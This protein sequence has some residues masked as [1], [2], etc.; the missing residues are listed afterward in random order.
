MIIDF[1]THAP[2]KGDFKVFLQDMDANK[3]DLSVLCPL[4]TTVTEISESNDYIYELTKQHPDRC[5]GFASVMPREPDAAK[6]LEHYIKDYGFK[7][8]KLHPPIQNFSPI[9][10]LIG[11]VIEKCIELDIP[12]L[13]HTGPIYSQNSIT[14]FGSPFLLDEL[15]IRYPKA[16]IV[17]AHVDPLAGDPAIVYK[18][19]NMFC[20]ITLRVAYL[21]QVIPNIGSFLL[22]QLRGDDNRILFGTDANP[23]RSWRF[24]YNLDAVYNMD[25]PEES[26]Q[27][28]LY[29]N[30]AKLLK[31]DVA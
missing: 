4:G 12:I 28:I 5:I 24:K 11:P 23:N 3:I 27:K 31:L 14:S 19:P 30:A 1:H 2:Q 17:L 10:P 7:G 9:D 8:L 16:K 22:H 15:S 21:A 13:F 18:N 26:K 29:K 20:D 6:T 25:I